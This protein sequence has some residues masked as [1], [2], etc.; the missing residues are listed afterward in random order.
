GILEL[1]GERGGDQAEQAQA[2]AFGE[3]ALGGDPLAEEPARFQGSGELAQD[4]LNGLHVSFLITAGRRADLQD[5]D[6]GESAAHAQRKSRLELG[7]LE[8]GGEAA[9]GSVE[10][11]E[12]AGVG[13]REPGPEEGR[14]ILGQETGA[15][16]ERPADLMRGEIV[17]RRVG[18]IEGL[19][20]PGER[21]EL[22][23]AEA[24]AEEA[25]Q[26]GPAAEGGALERRV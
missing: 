10:A 6:S 22:L 13:F 25:A 24:L 18:E 16:G 14:L 1:V 19:Q 5:E 17:E 8:H 7:A 2:L 12:G 9:G 23:G 26:P 11:V 20:P 15:G 3:A 4:E 21:F